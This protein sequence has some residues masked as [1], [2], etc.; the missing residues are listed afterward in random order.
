LAWAVT[1]L[2]WWLAGPLARLWEKTGFAQ[3][4]RVIEPAAVT[5]P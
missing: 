5:E 1:L 2:I 4:Y 3:N